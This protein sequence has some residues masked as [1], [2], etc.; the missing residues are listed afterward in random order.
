M[1]KYFVKYIE[2]HEI[3][4]EEFDTLYELETFKTVFR[5]AYEGKG[6]ESYIVEVH[7]SDGTIIRK[8]KI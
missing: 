8:I 5:L 3:V 7:Y 1:G 2:N 4:W 6:T